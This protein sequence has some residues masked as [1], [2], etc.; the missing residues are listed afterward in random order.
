MGKEK[1]LNEAVIG[2]QRILATYSD[3]GELLRVFYPTVDFKQWTD[4][5]HVGVKINDSQIIYL[6]NDINNIYNQNYL[7]DTNVLKTEIVNKYF[8]LKIDQ[9]D[10]I[11]IK[12]DVIIKKY[13]FTNENSIDLKVN[14]LVHSKL[15]SS[16]ENS[17]GG[18][19]FDDALLQYNHDYTVG[20]FAKEKLLSYQLHDTNQTISSGKIN[21]KDYIGM[22]SD[23]SISYDIGN[24]KAGETKIFTLFIFMKKNKDGESQEEIEKK[25]DKIRKFEVDKKIEE[26][27]KYWRKYV[28]EH[29]KLDISRFSDRVDII[30]KRSILLFPLLTNL[31]TG[32]IIAAPGIDEEREYSGGYA[33][34]WPRDAVFITKA[35]DILGMEN[36]VKD[37]YLKF[38]KNT[39]SN[40]GM[41]EQRFFTNGNLAPCWGYQ[42]DETASVV[43][44]V[45]EHYK[46]TKDMDFL[47]HSIKMCENAIDFLFRYIENLLQIDE[48]DVVK[49]EIQE[50]NKDKDKIEKHLSYDLWEMN[51]GVHLYSLASIYS[52]FDAMINLEDEIQTNNNNNRIKQEVILSRKLKLEKYKELIKSY[53]IKNLYDEKQKLLYRNL[54]DKKMDISI[55]GSVIPFEVFLPT[56]KAVVNTIEKINMTLRTY[57]GGYLRFEEDNYCGGKNPWVIST[58]WMA[59]YYAKIGENKKAIECLSFVVNTASEKGLLAEQVDNSLMKPAWVIGLG[60]SHAMF[61]LVIDALKNQL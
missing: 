1:F 9:I 50:K 24:L 58:L 26:V 8:K 22:T 19:I 55:L 21:G 38:C 12:D 29:M 36:E 2:N 14:F 54:S 41:W 56:E 46:M 10:A 33:Y 4:F 30:Y 47:K 28:Q 53:I 45:Y 49:K 20:I 11:C 23:S 3:K 34:C 13:K 39:Q 40:N 35:I 27:K 42:I 44:G 17:V 48:K 52:A 51:E 61:I 25:I 37:F 5:F 6:H 59:L 57:T 16:L 31:E 60:W 32:G 43:Y 18:R 15:L 7:Q